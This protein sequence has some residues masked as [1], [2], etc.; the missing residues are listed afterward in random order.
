[1]RAHLAGWSS[2]SPST[3]ASNYITPVCAGGASW[4]GTEN[5]RRQ[6]RPHAETINELRVTVATAP[7]VGKSYAVTLM[8]N[9]VASAL[10]CTISGTATSAQ[11]LTHSVSISALDSISMRFVPTGTPTAPG[12]S[13]W[14]FKQEA[15]NLFGMAGSLTTMPSAAGT[16]YLPP[17]GRSVGSAS[18]HAV[19]SFV[20]PTSG[21]FK[22]LVFWS[23]TA[24]AG[25]TSWALTFMKN[26]VAQT[27]TTTMSGANTTSSDT[28]NTVTVAAGD[29]VSVRIVTTG[30][31]AAASG[32]WGL[33]FDPD[34]DGE[35]FTGY[36]SASAMSPS[37]SATG[38]QALTESGD[39]WNATESTVYTRIA[40][41]VI[42][43]LYAVL[44]VAPGA[45]KSYALTVRKEVA[46]T[47][48]TVTVT[49]AAT[50][51]GNITGQRIAVNND[52]RLTVSSVP[53]GTPA[54]TV[55]KYSILT[56]ILDDPATLTDA[57]PGVII[58]TA[59]WSAVNDVGVAVIQNGDLEIAFTAVGGYGT[60]LSNSYYNLYGGSCY[61]QLT[62]AGN[63][64]LSMDV[65]PV[66][67]TNQAGT[68]TLV[69]IVSGNTVYAQKTIG[70]ST[71]TVA[72][73]AYNSAVHKFFRIRESQGTIYWDYA[74]IG[75]GSDWTNL[76]GGTLATSVFTYGLAA[77][78]VGLQTGIWSGTGTTTVKFDNF[79]V[80][81]SAGGGAYTKGNFF[82]LMG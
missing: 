37:T 11:D 68:D 80:A 25:V 15:A 34:T 8:V 19:G 26:N 82:A 46:T 47:A 33:S 76:P 54:T 10:T 6:V 42:K 48:A 53:S 63:Q 40:A 71:T 3:S 67:M 38:Y 58:D 66:Y 20:M 64:A 22:N 36:A 17:F 56:Q 12:T 24:P 49:G 7:G 21:V 35:S 39:A 4:S 45:A 69:F 32:S 9:G 16:N 73:V 29:T 61:A 43:A 23:N 72:S 62:D 57:F 41:T 13:F 70:G 74:T 55:V 75:D 81:G 14:N 60:L 65:L 51:T 28:S 44:S 77:L 31:P 1:M 59:K 78:A 30:S 52:D 18:T 50:T 79:N 27:L 2:T 5:A